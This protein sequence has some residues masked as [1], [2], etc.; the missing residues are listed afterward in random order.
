MIGVDCC[1][2]FVL[3]DVYGLIEIVVVEGE[4]FDVSIVWGYFVIG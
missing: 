3:I 4:V 1:D 2:C